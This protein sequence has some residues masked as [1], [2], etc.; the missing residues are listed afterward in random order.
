MGVDLDVISSPA[1]PN[2]RRNTVLVV[3][4]L[5]AV[6]LAAT[7][8][9]IARDTST[10]PDP[11]G[12]PSPPVPVELDLA[13]WAGDLPV[14]GPPQT[15]YW[16]EGVLHL[17]GAEIET[18]F[19]VGLIEVA[20]D[21]VMVGGPSSGAETGEVQ[22]WAVVRADQLVPLPEAA[23]WPSL[24]ADG[25]IA[26]WTTNPTS[27]TTQFVT[28]DTETGAELASRTLPGRFDGSSDRLQMV[29]I[30]ADGIGYWVDRAS[31]PPVTR[32]DVRADTVAPTDLPFDFS[33]TFNL[34]AAPIADLWVGFEDSYLSPDRTTVVFTSDARLRVRPVGSNKPDDV[35]SLMLP[36]GIPEMRL[37]DAYSDRGMW[38]VWWETNQTVLLD[39]SGDG[40]SY[41]V[42]C[43]TTDGS[44]E[45]VFHLGPN[46]NRGILYQPDWER[47]WAFARFPVTG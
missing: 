13:A 15:P 14:G 8:I 21:T 28:W 20:G 36:D 1:R 39:A 16:H 18:P 4:A 5:V 2:Q 46:S 38:W 26:Y 6:V 7:A 9:G 32:W 24:S 25:R 23:T 34:Q 43:S 47:D 29:G 19:P 37:W 31:D 10:R 40:Q 12:P 27:N 42:R 41:L 30:D 17:H 33:T 35:V 3:S 22:R 11:A 44:C 45:L